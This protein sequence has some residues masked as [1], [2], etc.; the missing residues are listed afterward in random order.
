VKVGILASGYVYAPTASS[1]LNS[2]VRINNPTVSVADRDHTT[3]VSLIIGGANGVAPNSEIY[4]YTYTTSAGFMD[5]IDAFITRGVHIIN[6]SLKLGDGT[7]A[8]ESY[9]YYLDYVISEYYLTIIKSSGNDDSDHYVTSPGMGYNV[10]T[11]GATN[12]TGDTLDEYSSYYEDSSYLTEKPNLVAPGSYFRFE[13][14]YYYSFSDSGSRGTSFSAPLVTGAIVLLV[15][16]NPDL[17]YEPNEIMSIIMTGTK[18][19]NFTNDSTTT[20]GLKEM[21]GAG[22]LDIEGMLNVNGTSSWIDDWFSEGIYEKQFYV[23]D[24]KNLVITN[25]WQ[26]K[27]FDYNFFPTLNH[28]ISNYDMELYDDTGSLIASINSL[29]SNTEVIR[30][31]TVGNHTY[32]LKIIMVDKDSSVSDFGDLSIKYD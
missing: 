8:Y 10:I 16:T 22:L 3:I 18:D 25:T 6:I 28:K 7:A 29:Y 23:P 32:T 19:T 12:E 21:S 27:Y 4:T 30:I 20:S 5:E 15:E 24:N 17:L 26:L 1:E 11:V 14:Y 9:T 13:E 2:H 31:T